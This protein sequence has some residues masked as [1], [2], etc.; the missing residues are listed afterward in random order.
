[1][2]PSVAGAKS[3]VGETLCETPWWTISRVVAWAAVPRP[4]L[5]SAR[6]PASSRIAPAIAQ[7]AQGRACALVVSIRPAPG[8]HYVVDEQQRGAACALSS[9]L[10]TPTPRAL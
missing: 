3:A 1:M 4:P 2:A 6:A 10:E 5:I 8:L 9:P 7:R